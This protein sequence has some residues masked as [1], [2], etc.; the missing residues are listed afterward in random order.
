[1][2]N[3]NIVDTNGSGGTAGRI[4]TP[5][6]AT[7]TPGYDYSDGNG[8]LEFGSGTDGAL[9]FR[10][11]QGGNVQMSGT[12]TPSGG[13][14]TV[15]GNLTANGRVTSA[16]GGLQAATGLVTGQSGLPAI[17]TPAVPAAST[18]V[19]NATG[20]DVVVYVSGGTGVNVSVNG[21]ATGLSSGTFYVHGNAGGNG[22]TISLGA[23]TAAPTWVWQAV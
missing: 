1:M 17:S 19:S 11:D 10:V 20:W 14:L 3:L 23:Y 12:V 8:Y 2:P 13:T 16:G 9:P 22:G 21:T 6:L 4:V 5:V 7:R 18:P 15:P